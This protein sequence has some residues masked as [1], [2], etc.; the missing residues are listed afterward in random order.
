MHDAMIEYLA[1]AAKLTV[2][3]FNDR[4]AEGETM[5]SILE[6]AG[7][8]AEQITD[9]YNNAHDAALQ[10]AVDEGWL[11]QEQA[12]LMDGHMQG[13]WGGGSGQRGGGCGGNMRG[14]YQGSNL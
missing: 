12:D 3:T 2:A 6:S 1:G 11:S 10:T 9:A 4:L 13:M 14:F 5:V 7:L 8:S